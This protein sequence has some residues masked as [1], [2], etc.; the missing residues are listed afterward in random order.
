[1]RTAESHSSQVQEASLSAE[2]SKLYGINFRTP[3]LDLLEFDL[4][5]QVPFDIMHVC[6]EGVMPH[7]ITIV[8]D[9]LLKRHILSRGVFLD[10]NLFPSQF[11]FKRN[12]PSKV[13]SSSDFYQTALQI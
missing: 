9:D 10:F 12:S 7:V 11:H 5:M 6:M 8:V 2:Q 1:M 3:L 4:F 13:C